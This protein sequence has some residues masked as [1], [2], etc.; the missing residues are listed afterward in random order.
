MT[1][2]ILKMMRPRLSEKESG[3]TGEFMPE[4]IPINCTAYWLFSSEKA[5]QPVDKRTLLTFT[6]KKRSFQPQWY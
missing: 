4:T 2:V 5:S 3:M 1:K 6:S